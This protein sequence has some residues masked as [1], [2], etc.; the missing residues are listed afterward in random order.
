MIPLAHPSASCACKVRFHVMHTII[1][2]FFQVILEG[3]FG[4]G[5][6]GD[7]AVDDFYLLNET[8]CPTIYGNGELNSFVSFVLVSI[9]PL[10]GLSFL[11]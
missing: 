5:I 3:A 8:E 7:I 4:N 1:F 11:T 6:H 9:F 10:I 2:F